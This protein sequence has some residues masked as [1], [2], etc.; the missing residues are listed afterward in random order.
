M[1]H[2]KTKVIRVRRVNAFIRT[3]EFFHIYLFLVM[4]PV[5]NQDPSIELV[6]KELTEPQRQGPSS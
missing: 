2:F 6:E 1:L 4:E 3:A 5:Q